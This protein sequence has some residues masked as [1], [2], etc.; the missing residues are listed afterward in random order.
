M[1]GGIDDYENLQ[2]AVREWLRKIIL[3]TFT[4]GIAWLAQMYTYL[5]DLF[6]QDVKNFLLSPGRHHNLVKHF[7]FLN[8][9]DREFHY[10]VRPWRR[11]AIQALR[12][13][14]ESI[15]EYAHYDLTARLKKLIFSIP[16]TI[17]HQAFENIV[18]NLKIHEDYN[19]HVYDTVNVEVLFQSIPRPEIL[20]HIYSSESYLT[21]DRNPR[22]LNHHENGREVIRELYRA[23]CGSIMLEVFS[24]FNS[25]IVTRIQ[26][27]GMIKSFTKEENQRSLRYRIIRMPKTQLNEIANL[28]IAATVKRIRDLEKELG[29]FFAGR[30]LVENAEKEMDSSLRSNTNRRDRPIKPADEIAEEH[31]KWLEDQTEWISRDD[32][33]ASIDLKPNANYRKNSVD[34]SNHSS[35]NGDQDN[36]E[37]RMINIT[38]ETML[39]MSMKQFY[40]DHDEEDL[41]LGLDSRENLRQDEADPALL[42]HLFVDADP[43]DYSIATERASVAMA[44]KPKPGHDPYF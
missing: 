6:R 1:Y 30:K 9:V 17:K 18:P 35:K 24:N 14:C 39:A 33:Q 15:G 11:Q 43:M 32:N 19:T 31:R 34:Y 8:G 27:Y 4:V 22:T 13:K 42:S 44:R 3:D 20:D 2:K 7:V 41:A 28:D 26:Q 21:D 16:A 5:L 38:D 25:C 23:S 29:N 37:D 40:R 10:T 12:Y 36:K